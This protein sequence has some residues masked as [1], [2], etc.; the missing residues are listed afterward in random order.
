MLTY[1]LFSLL[2]YLASR[3]LEVSNPAQTRRKKTATAWGGGCEVGERLARHGR[4]DVG[5]D[6]AEYLRT[7]ARTRTANPNSLPPLSTPEFARTDS[8]QPPHAEHQKKRKL[9]SNPGL[10]QPRGPTTV[11]NQRNAP[12]EQNPKQ[13]T[14]SKKRKEKRTF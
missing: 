12:L 11:M 8:H 1:Q 2:S 9:Q 7:N 14:I 6:H 5:T 4:T 3:S 13:E 10:T